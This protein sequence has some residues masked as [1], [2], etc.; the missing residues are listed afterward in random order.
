MILWRK[1]SIHH[2]RSLLH[3][4]G[5]YFQLEL[6]KSPCVLTTSNPLLVQRRLRKDLKIGNRYPHRSPVSLYNRYT[7]FYIRIFTSPPDHP[8]YSVTSSSTSLSS[9]RVIGIS[10]SSDRICFFHLSQSSKTAVPA[11]VVPNL[12][13]I[14][15]PLYLQ[16]IP[17]SACR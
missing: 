4:R 1:Y 9:S 11:A 3:Y 17:Q 14:L 13:D 15:R 7:Y 12:P 10:D 5:I 16:H 6:N 8:S 2:K